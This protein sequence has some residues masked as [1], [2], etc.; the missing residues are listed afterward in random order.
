MSASKRGKPLEMSALHA[1]GVAFVQQ[2]AK[3][4]R[5]LLQ[6]L[7][8]WLRR[9]RTAEVNMFLSYL[10]AEASGSIDFEH[11]IVRSIECQ[12]EA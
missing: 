1:P 9:G 5:V 6:M 3:G 10:N 7:H 12:P 4:F 11:T 2:S 8:H